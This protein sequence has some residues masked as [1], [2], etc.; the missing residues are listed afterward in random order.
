MEQERI[1]RK[2]REESKRQPTKGDNTVTQTALFDLTSPHSQ[3]VVPRKSS[4]KDLTAPSIPKD[5]TARSFQKD[6]NERSLH[7]KETTEHNRRHSETSILS[8]RS[9]RRGHDAEDMTSAFIVPDITIRNPVVDTSQVP[10]LTKEA[11]KVLDGLANHNGKNCTLCKGIISKGEN[12]EHAKETIKISKPVPVSERILSATENDEDH[13]IRPSQAP[14]LALA[15]VMKG[16]DDEL[17]HL[18]IQL[19]KHQTLYNGQDPALSKRSRKSVHNKIETLLQAIDSKADQIYA[20]YDVLEGQKQDG[21]EISDEEVEVTLQSIGVGV[22]AL[23]LRGGE[24]EK[25]QAEKKSNETSERHPWDLESEA[26]SE[27]PWE[28][29]ESTLE[30]TKGGFSKETPPINPNHQCTRPR[31]LRL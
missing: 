28:G 6:V 30:S 19:T 10:E 12:H 22:A 16:L 4:V 5:I 25:Q 26:E 13:T 20:L 23:H 18:K 7:R 9:R 2:Q 11:R 8:I 1:E 27:L 31:H 21:R 14:G 24:G 29:I 17:A 15:T 3:Q